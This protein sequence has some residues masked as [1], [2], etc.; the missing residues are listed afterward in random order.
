MLSL[1]WP[2]LLSFSLSGLTSL[3]KLKGLATVWPFSSR[4]SL[5]F[6]FGFPIFLSSSF[7]L[8]FSSFPMRILFTMVSKPLGTGGILSAL[9][10]DLDLDLNFGSNV[11]SLAF[12][13]NS[14]SVVDK[15]AF[16]LNR[17][18]WGTFQC[19]GITDLDRSYSMLPIMSLR[20]IIDFGTSIPLAD[21]IWSWIFLLVPSL[22]KDDL[23]YSFSIDCS[24]CL[25]LYYSVPGGWDFVL[26]FGLNVHNLF[27]LSRI[28]CAIF[29][30][31]R[32]YRA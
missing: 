3:K 12:L 15:Y 25:N 7:F 24:A 13:I 21:I 8:Y 11:H 26:V 5:T 31:L 29:S 16:A 23:N 17:L 32:F 10:C 19:V 22:A 14:I 18:P 6:T 1:L 2:S 27:S 28:S 30:I 9:I 20:L 4:N